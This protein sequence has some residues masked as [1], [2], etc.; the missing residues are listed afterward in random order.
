[1]QT[2]A[3]RVDATRLPRPGT[4]VKTSYT[5]TGGLH[6]ARA[7]RLSARFYAI[8]AQTPE[9]RVTLE[10]F[11]KERNFMSREEVDAYLNRADRERDYHYR[12]LLSPGTDREAEGVDLK[13]Y[14]RR[15]MNAFKG[16]VSWVGVAHVGVGAHTD[17]AHVHLIVSTN[18]K[19]N[20]REL[21][22]LRTHAERV[23]Q[24]MRQGA[25]ELP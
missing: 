1:M 11:T 15:V 4:V 22:S 18:K 14:T 13:A 25:G 8:S 16:C 10:T 21:G 5:R 12:V 19:A 2:V 3:E 9:K 7:V 6:S 17:R 20:R 24:M 23:W